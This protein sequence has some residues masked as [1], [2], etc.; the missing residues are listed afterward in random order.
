MGELKTFCIYPFRLSSIS[1][2]KE[3]KPYAEED[4]ED[5]GDEWEVQQQASK[6]QSA[7]PWTNS[8]RT[9]PKCKVRLSNIFMDQLRKDRT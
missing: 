9:R 7:S 8:E 5:G 6:V 2:V 3:E 1:V 4:V